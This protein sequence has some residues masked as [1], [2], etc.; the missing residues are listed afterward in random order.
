MAYSHLLTG[1]QDQGPC[2]HAYFIT[3][4]DNT[5]VKSYQRS[6]PD[7]CVLEGSGVVCTLILFLFDK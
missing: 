4:S 7:V 6:L 2:C 5:K 1:L 3:F